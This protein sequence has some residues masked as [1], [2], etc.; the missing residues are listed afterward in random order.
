ML[1]MVCFLQ[2]LPWPPNLLT[3]SEAYQGHPSQPRE[4]CDKHIRKMLDFMSSHGPHLI[5][6]VLDSKN[7][8]F[9]GQFSPVP[10]LK[11]KHSKPAGSMV[12]PTCA[13]C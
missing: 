6:W 9:Y 1:S 7:S 8:R 5:V 12:S 11:L 3:V 2:S 10:K 4:D 13:L